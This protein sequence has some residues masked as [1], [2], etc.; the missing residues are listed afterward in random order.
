METSLFL[1]KLA[2]AAA[3]PVKAGAWLRSRILGPKPKSNAPKNRAAA[4]LDQRIAEISR[5]GHRNVLVVADEA[6]YR[7][8]AQQLPDRRVTWASSSF[9]DI[10]AGAL[11]IGRVALADFDCVLVAG[12]DAALAYR[13]AIRQMAAAETLRPLLW[14]S[15]NFEF[16]AGTMPLPAQ[17][18]DADVYIF[19]HFADMMGGR[20][21]L[22][23]T[24]EV[25]DEA[26][27]VE[28]QI[29]L[30][31]RAGVRVRVSEWL[32][33]RQGAAC[34]HHRCEHPFL[35][36]GRHFRWRGTGVVKWRQ[37]ICMLHGSHDF[38]R[39]DAKTEHKLDAGLVRGADL[40]VTLP[41]Y[42][43]DMKPEGESV[44]VLRGDTISTA[45]RSPKNRI[46]Q[47]VI[48]CKDIPNSFEQGAGVRFAGYGDS[49]WYLLKS[50]LATDG[51]THASIAANHSL[52]LPLKGLG[53]RFRP[54]EPVLPLLD[55]LRAR[56]LMLDPHPLPVAEPGSAVEFGFDFDLNAPP[57]RNFDIYAFDRE[58]R[59]V[60]TK[61]WSKACPGPV[62]AD[63]LVGEVGLEREAIGLLAVCPDWT[64][65]GGDPRGR[66]SAGSFIARARATGDFDVTEFQNG[67]RNLGV[68]IAE[69]PHWLGQ[70][71][72]IV[73]RTNVL[74]G[75]PSGPDYR[76]GVSTA[77]VSGDLSYGTAAEIVVKLVNDVG[78]ER[79]AVATLSAFRHRILWIDELIP[80]WNS[81][82]GDRGGAVLVQSLDADLNCNM[83]AVYRGR[84]VSVQHMWGY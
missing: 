72:M 68:K 48:D 54:A 62:F 56:G 76:V 53:S 10:A 52:S 60:A 43:L 30:R 15:A 2:K 82:L 79:S 13:Q 80:D 25:F 83:L 63:A 64:A 18:D 24:I 34:V 22:L 81:H 29:L 58:G 39:S 36:G 27:K 50:D 35:T 23:V 19:N 71:R 7:Q 3:N 17:C 57:L 9:G 33:N 4:S 84:A 11:T 20:D 49:F 32:A 59:H 8:V 5:A 69:F 67:W 73:G 78:Q 28:R 74:C 44:E 40:A 61:R 26:T 55:S 41:N 6:I 66:G 38:G 65:E 21:P 16:C 45:K 51:G 37:S 14:V 12:S 75:V 46:E 77:N 31:P 42:L 70:D 1:S 47:I